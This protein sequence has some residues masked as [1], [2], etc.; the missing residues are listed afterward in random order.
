M[1]N[2]NNFLFIFNGAM[3]ISGTAIGAGMLAL[4]LISSG[5]WFSFALI[6]L[7]ITCYV[8]YSSSLYLLETS[9]AFDVDYNYVSL[10]YKTLGT[11][12]HYIATFSVTFVPFI[13]L[14]A[15]SSGGGS[16]IQKLLFQLLDITILT[17]QAT[18][19]F[20]GLLV[21]C[22]FFGSYFVDKVCSISVII[23]SIALLMVISMM[24]MHVSSDYLFPTVSVS[25][26]IGYVWFILPIFITSFGFHA[27]FPS[28]IKHFERNIKHVTYSLMIGIGTC[29]VL[30][31][32]W[33]LVFMGNVERSVLMTLGDNAN[34]AT[35][36]TLLSRNI[37]S[38]WMNYTLSVFS[39]FAVATSFLGVGL[40][41]IDAVKDWFQLKETKN[42]HI[43][44]VLFVFIPI[45][46]FSYFYPD[47][48]VSAIQ[49]A[50]LFATIF[51]VIL[52]PLMALQVRRKNLPTKYK[53][54]GGQV[55]LWF[56][57][58]FGIIGFI[59]EFYQKI[60]E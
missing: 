6:L 49:Y 59:L 8:T 40:G 7:L 23:M 19:I 9:M 33:L 45:T 1:K 35:F 3:I 31:A 27:T 34:L 17:S 13:L 52:P 60:L 58:L 54:S 36:V 38:K 12:G 16:I 55:R 11:I 28:I 20:N 42:N 39:Q 43:F 47:Y 29:F 41:I 57:L 24:S 46:F 44:T 2:E 22:L 15:Y 25:E 4:P 5:I 10:S 26:R 50:A 51:I 37:D 21:T 56:V 30:Y 48:F 18:V 14:Y 53:V 32:L